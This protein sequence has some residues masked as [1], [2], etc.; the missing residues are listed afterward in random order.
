[1]TDRIE[2][3]LLD[4]EEVDNVAA[5]PDVSQ[6][7]AIEKSAQLAAPQ[8]SKRMA[9]V[10]VAGLAVV[11]L[12]S[13]F[14][15]PQEATDGRYFTI[16][17]FKNFTG[18]PCPGCGLTHSFCAIGKGDFVTAFVYNILGPPLF[19]LS[20][21]IWIR[22]ICVLAGRARFAMAFDQTIMRLKPARAF[23]IAF[24]LFGVGRIIYLSI[25]QP[26]YFSGSPLA[27]LIEMFTR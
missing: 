12:T 15:R 21:L 23:M 27:Q 8:P 11:F 14:Y 26:S 17:G 2:M 3:A 5:L 18:L 13:I 9:A 10:I 1:M 24:V 20:L 22:S 6:Q 16:C 7:I 19:L 4:K 25:Y